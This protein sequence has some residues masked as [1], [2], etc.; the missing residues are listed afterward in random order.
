MAVGAIDEF[1]GDRIGAVRPVGS[2][3]C[4]TE[5]GFA[6]EGD[7]LEPVTRS[8]VKKSVPFFTVATRQ[9]LFDLKHYNEADA[10]NEGFVERRPV[11][12]K[13]L[14]NCKLGF[15]NTSPPS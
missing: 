11:I 7:K 12:L 8:T 15:Q 3:T 5:S 2:A 13:Y 6:A 10:E 1:G 4:V 9:R 14:L